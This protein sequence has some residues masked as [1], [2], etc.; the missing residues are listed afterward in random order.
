[1]LCG[2]SNTNILCKC[3]TLPLCQPVCQVCMRALSWLAWCAYSVMGPLTCYAGL[4][5][6]RIGSRCT[7]CFST[8]CQA[9]CIIK[10][11]SCPFAGD[12][13]SYTCFPLYLARKCDPLIL[14]VHVLKHMV[15]M[16]V[17]SRINFAL[18]WLA[19]GTVD[20]SE[21]CERVRAHRILYL[22]C[23]PMQLC[24][25]MSACLCED[26]KSVALA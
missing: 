15:C 4:V 8:D 22:Y 6:F 16:Y 26:E 25:C 17:S 19:A 7:V 23:R 24:L 2:G 21:E 10:S 11:C 3:C 20:S 13:D 14:S 9:L 12:A 18:C 5:C 1:M